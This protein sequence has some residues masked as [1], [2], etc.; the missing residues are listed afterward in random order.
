VQV[1]LKDPTGNYWNGSIFSGTTESAAW[2]ATSYAAGSWSYTSGSNSAP[3]SLST[4]GTYTVH[5]RTTDNA[6]NVTTNSTYTF[7]FD[8]GAPSV[9]IATPASNAYYGNTIS[10]PQIIELISPG[11]S[12][13]RTIAIQLAIFGFF[14][15]VMAT[16]MPR[17]GAI[18]K[19]TGA[20]PAYLA[21]RGVPSSP[22]ELGE[23]DCISF[24]A[25]SPADRWVY[26]GG[27]APQR[28]VVRPR[29]IVNT[30]QAAIDAAKAGLGITRVLSYQLASSVADQSLRLILEDFA[31]DS[32]PVSLLHREDRLPQAKV[33]SFIAYAAPRLRQALKSGAL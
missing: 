4:N 6:G 33:Q 2:Q 30:A 29:L 7:T 17:V 28:I 8:N 9:A 15:A 32:I 25:L 31:P 1:T 19:V 20:S 22:R 11:S 26:P 27:K 23:Y 16:Q 3:G 21:E 24:T 12:T 13:M 18:R 5:V 14:G 10:T